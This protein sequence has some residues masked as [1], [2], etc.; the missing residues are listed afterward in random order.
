MINTGYDTKYKLFKAANMSSSTIDKGVDRMVGIKL[1]K[2]SDKH[3]KR[4]KPVE[5]TDKGKLALD[6]LGHLDRIV[7]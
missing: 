2:L 5:L 6:Y 3:D 1:L 7:D 4:S